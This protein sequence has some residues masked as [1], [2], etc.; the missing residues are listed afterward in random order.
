VSPLGQVWPLHTCQKA[1]NVHVKPRCQSRRY[2]LRSNLI[3]AEGFL[4][5]FSNILPTSQHNDLYEKMESLLRAVVCRCLLDESYG[6]FF[7]DD[8][9][10][11]ARWPLNPEQKGP[12]E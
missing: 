2:Q 10:V 12:K 1:L 11:E 5:S 8:A 3:H 7:R 4:F 9:A 6:S